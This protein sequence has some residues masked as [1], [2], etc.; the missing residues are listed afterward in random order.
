MTPQA[1]ARITPSSI[2]WETGF[3]A[4]RLDAF[5]KIVERVDADGEKKQRHEKA[6]CQMCYEPYTGG[7]ASTTAGTERPC[8]ICGDRM[9][10]GNGD[11]DKLCV[12]CA[13]RA[14]LCRHCGGDIDM[15]HRR[16]PRD[17]NPP[18]QA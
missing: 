3:A 8:G 16:K 5:R 6:N 17:L 1:K 15:K 18:E 14:G 10:F 12:A 7:R 13:K 11:P 9:L 4:I 2:E